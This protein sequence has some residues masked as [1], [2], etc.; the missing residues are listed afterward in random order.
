VFID[1]KTFMAC[2]ATAFRPWPSAQKQTL[3]SRL[4]CQNP[5]RV[6]KAVTWLREPRLLLPE[7]RTRLHELDPDMP[8]AE[9]LDNRPGTDTSPRL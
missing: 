9:V 4:R 7:I 5:N 6:L 2:A 3:T 8:F 1:S